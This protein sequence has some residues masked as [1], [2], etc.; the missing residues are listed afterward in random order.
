MSLLFVFSLIFFPLLVL[1]F[2][3][4]EF[5]LSNPFKNKKTS[6]N[7]NDS[8]LRYAQEDSETV[9]SYF[10]GSC[11]GSDSSAAGGSSVE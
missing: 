10:V 4:M 1:G 3:L 5:G 9:D 8:N 2:W 7:N 11:S 6:S